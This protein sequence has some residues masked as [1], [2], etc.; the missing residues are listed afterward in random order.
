MKR[1]VLICASAALILAPAG[2]LL[3]AQD[4]DTF[5]PIVSYQYQDSLDDTPTT[6]TSPVVSYQYYDWPGDDNL[7]F[8]NSAN[9]SYL[10]AGSP[11]SLSISGPTSISGGTSATYQAIATFSD[12]YVQDFSNS[13]LFTF[14]L[15]PPSYAGIGGSTLFVSRDVR[16]G[17]LSLQAYYR[18]SSGQVTSPAFTVS[19]NSGFFANL[20]ASAQF[21]GGSN[22]QATLN[23]SASGGA[24]PYTFRWDEDGD[25]NYSDATGQQVAFTFTSQGGTYPIGLEVTDATGAKAYARY[26]LV[27]NKPP[28][29]GEPIG[30][31]IPPQT[32]LPGALSSDGTTLFD[33]NSTQT[34]ARAQ[35]GLLV[36]TH[37][38]RSNANPD[39]HWLTTLAQA[40]ECKL[41]TASPNIIIFDWED[42]ANVD[43]P[44]PNL[45]LLFQSGVLVF[46]GVPPELAVFLSSQFDGIDFVA[47]AYNCRRS[48]VR[49]KV[50]N[51]LVNQIKLYTEG[52]NP[53]V[54]PSKPIQLLGHSGGGFIVSGAAQRLADIA[55]VDLVTMLDT[56]FPIKG[57]VESQIAEAYMERYRSSVYGFLGL[58]PHVPNGDAN[59]FWV[60]NH[61][62]GGLFDP[63]STGDNGH[64]YSHEWYIE[65]V[66]TSG[67]D[68]FNRAPFVSPSTRL[69]KDSRAVQLRKTQ[70]TETRL[71]SDLSD[72]RIEGFMTF[73]NVVST[74]AGFNITETAD[75][76]LTKAFDIP[77][78][79]V[80]IKFRYKFA[81]PGDGDFLSVNWNS[82]PALYM[83]EDLELSRSDFV[84]AEIPLDFLSLRSGTLTFT[85]VSRG[86]PNAIIDI[87]DIRFGMSE[88][89][90][91][92][93]LT[94][95]QEAALG[96]DPLKADSDGDG[97]S[98]GDEVNSYRTNP[99]IADSDGDWVSDGDEI[100]AGT[101]P[102]NATS[103]PASPTPLSAVSRKVHGAAGAF[104]INLPP[105]GSAG[106]ECRSGGANNDYEVVFTFPTAITLSGATVA[107]GTGKSASVQGVPVVSTD[108]R[109]VTVNLTGVTNAQTMNVQLNNVYDGA[110]TGNVVVRMGALLGD[111][112]GN[113]TVNSSDVSLTKL[114]SGQV[115]DATNFREDVTVN[116][117]INSSDVSTV[118]LNS[119]TA[120]P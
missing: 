66:N 1:L 61:F 99:L 77:V 82:L 6:I 32:P 9:V 34:H 73:G 117:S 50:A 48:Y 85:L 106:I 11:V 28:A 17:T 15:P 93:G 20:T 60:A 35:N 18:D 83:G 64:G 33:P 65:T 5:S 104:D 53:A 43:M 70:L 57:D 110:N 55:E 40:I 68:G 102:N 59:H 95:D 88:D 41:G 94:N 30:P 112:T 107:P 27:V 103:R 63:I 37:G 7:T 13:S 100:A 84:E 47:D 62:K 118:K 10:Y 96:T 80:S 105:N 25:G 44:F 26:P 2:S 39:D 58:S 12:G 119:G 79:A 76:G 101:D 54:D 108:G 3:L 109:Q 74:G 114:K 113:G 56:P 16:P 98:D 23:G 72:Q 87:E 75:A 45:D 52:S 29:S 38:M 22:Y 89:P 46:I 120:L 90:D 14:A 42:D 91:G 69:D 36:I 24:P 49:N 97:I 19:V 78:G 92:D 116:G 86:S 51:R 31:V 4:A 81:M 71:A 67:V 111:T 8:S 115:V 21:T